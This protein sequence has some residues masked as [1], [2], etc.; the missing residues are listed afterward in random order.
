[1][2]HIDPRKYF[3]DHEKTLGMDAENVT[4]LANPVQPHSEGE[5]K[6]V[7]SDPLKNPELNM[8]YFGDPYDM[9]VMIASIRRTMEI[10]KNFGNKLGPLYV[11]KP[12][13]EKHGWKPG[14]EL[15]DAL[16]E[17]W[18]LH[19]ATTVYHPTSSCR[20]GDVVDPLLRVRG[21]EGLRVADASV[22]P[23]IMSGN[24]N[25]PSI[26]IGEKGAEMIAEAN[27]V[28]LEQ[29]VKPKVDSPP[30]RPVVPKS[31]L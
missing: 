13:A 12:I 8:N 10:A 22:M 2:W 18:V 23:N 28:V 6:L 11:P 31:N 4:F 29:I 9:K 26:M 20:I 17:D 14:M 27:N 30:S 15:S 19:Y 1:L 24:T 3:E 25:A 21:V 7:S 16:L 5:V